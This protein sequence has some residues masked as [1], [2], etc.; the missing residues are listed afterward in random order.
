MVV[1]WLIL[2]KGKWFFNFFR[3]SYL[4]TKIGKLCFSKYFNC[5]QNFYARIKSSKNIL[6]ECIVK[7]GINY[8]EWNHKSIII[9]KNNFISNFTMNNKITN[10]FSFGTTVLD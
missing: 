6:K 7:L 10:M 5:G 4:K 8:L 2:L 3:E 1:F 9:N